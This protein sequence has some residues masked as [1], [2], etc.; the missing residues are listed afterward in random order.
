MG[1][2]SGGCGTVFVDVT[3][4]VITRRVT[5][6][7]LEV[8][9]VLH[10]LP[11]PVRAVFEAGPTGY[12]LVRRARAQG[13][14]MV[15]CSPASVERGPGDRIKTDKRDAIRLARRFTAG[16]LRLGGGPPEEE[17]EL[18]GPGRRREGLRPGLM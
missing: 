6:R 14:E 3:G 17:E 11:R 15:V 18:R 9:D 13:I 16:E 1:V 8:L 5:G 10:G 2:S 12:G 4:E 7:P